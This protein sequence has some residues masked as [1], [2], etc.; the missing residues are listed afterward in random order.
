MNA[1][2]KEISF[3]PLRAAE[4]YQAQNYPALSNYFLEI[5]QFLEK[6]AW[7]ELNAERSRFVNI[8][9]KHFL[10]FFSQEDYVLGDEEGECFIRANSLI[11]NL[12]AMSVFKTTDV[13]LELI[14]NQQANFV[15]V[16]ALLN[17]R[18]TS[19]FEIAPFFEAHPKFATLWYTKYFDLF[20]GGTPTKTIYENALRHVAGADSRWE[21]SGPDMSNFYFFPT[22]FAM[23]QEAG[24]KKLYH[25]LVKPIMAQAKITNKPNPKS[26]AI[27]TAGWVRT[28]AV[29]KSLAPYVEALR[30]DYDLTLVILGNYGGSDNFDK[31][32]FKT[33]KNISISGKE[34][35]LQDILENDFSLVYYPDI[36]MRNE[37]RHLANI[38]IAPI[39]VMGYGHPAST[40]GSEID[41]FVGGQETESLRDA[42]KNYS[43][44]LVAIP[45]LGAFAVLP[46]KRFKATRQ[47]QS[48]RI[49]INCP[50]YAHKCTYPHL[51]TL[52]RIASK[53]KK[54]VLFRFFVGQGLSFHNQT[55]PFA[56]EVASVVGEGHTEIIE[57]RPYDEYQRLMSEGAFSLDSAPFGGYN[58][59]VDS[60][61]VGKPS[62]TLE[63]RHA[64]GR[65]AAAAMRR[66]GM[67]ELV[68]KT[69]SEYV[70]IVLK[71]IDDDA[72]RE[73]VVRRLAEVD[74][75]A[76]LCRKGEGEAFKRAIDFLIANHARLKA[77]GSRE[78]IF[79]D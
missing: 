74:L 8:F 63:G 48:D 40:H 50:W 11:S 5:L 57:L 32:W 34:F 1:A 23:D 42:Q 38:R 79:I 47:E 19:R 33:I 56:Q 68:A 65:L 17:A 71:L 4:L 3:N 30:H 21:Y 14:R 16:L 73:D 77:E 41:Y 43:E 70:S 51:L 46:E 20:Y 44:R 36:G 7:S 26:I 9:M 18:C 69:P 59:I 22:Y 29:Y 52:G 55:I 58:T 67:N 27:V 54:K 15:K 6:Q 72:Y 39:Q 62:V 76:S 64:P 35:K 37:D 25:G 66:V 61:A 45:G 78:P 13:W 24:L 31:S 10:F 2:H 12:A 53:A 49:I 60:L 75:D 28:S